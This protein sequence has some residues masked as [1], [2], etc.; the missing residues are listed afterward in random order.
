MLCSAILSCAVLCCALQYSPVL[1]SAVLRLSLAPC[2]TADVLCCCRA[3]QAVVHYTGRLGAKQGWRFDSTFDHKDAYGGPEP[4]EFVVGSPK[5]LFSTALNCSVWFSVS[6]GTVLCCVWPSR[7]PY[8]QAPV[9]YELIMWW[10][11]LVAQCCLPPSCT[12]CSYCAVLV[13]H[14]CR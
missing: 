9:C 6:A 12:C 4:F 5:V 3:C 11:L 7:C 13:V 2:F 10:A 14:A 1:C 8:S